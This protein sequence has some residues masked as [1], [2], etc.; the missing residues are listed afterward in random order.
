LSRLLVDAGRTGAVVV[1]VAVALVVVVVVVVV[2]LVVVLAAVVVAL[3]V[4]L[5]VVFVVVV[6]TLF[7]VLAAVVAARPGC[8]FT[9]GNVNLTKLSERCRCR[10]VVHGTAYSAMCQTRPPFAYST[11]RQRGSAFVVLLN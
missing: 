5:V 9:C 2:A 6:V 8:F 4:A 10:G 11:M 3:V 7:V 1:V